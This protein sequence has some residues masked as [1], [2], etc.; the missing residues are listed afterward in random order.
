[1][2]FT[3]LWFL[4]NEITQRVFGRFLA[5]TVNKADLLFSYICEIQLFILRRHVFF[6]VT[7]ARLVNII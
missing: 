7:N 1:M 6:L 3:T 2:K 4:K 5:A